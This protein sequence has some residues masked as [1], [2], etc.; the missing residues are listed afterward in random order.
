MTPKLAPREATRS[1]T[2]FGTGPDDPAWWV[3]VIVY[4]MCHV[5]TWEN[6]RRRGDWCARFLECLLV[7]ATV[8]AFGATPQSRNTPDKITADFS[9]DILPIFSDNCFTCHGPDEK[10]R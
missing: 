4:R 10:S 2:S 3:C 8:S 7:A 5:R 6:L 9:R 1:T